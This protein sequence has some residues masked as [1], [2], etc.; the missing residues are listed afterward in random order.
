MPISRVRSVTVTSMMLVM[1]MPPTSRLIAATAPSSTVNVSLAEVRVASSWDWF[2]IRYGA[3]AVLVTC[4]CRLRIAVTSAW[5]AS[6]DF[7]VRRLDEDR[8]DGAVAGQRR[9]DGAAAARPRC[10]SGRSEPARPC[11]ASTPDDGERHAA[12]CD[13]LADRAGRPEQ[14]VGHGLADHRRPRP[15]SRRWR[16]NAL[17][18]PTGLLVAAK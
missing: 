13:L 7:G 12:D 16:V 5:A 4:S 17:P 2:R 6:T 18:E 8:R 1:P 14:V 15:A 9:L 3:L 10:R 11:S